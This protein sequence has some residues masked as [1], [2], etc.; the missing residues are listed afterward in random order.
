MGGSAHA[1]LPP[2]N[3][4]LSLLLDLF[5]F[6]PP[7]LL[8]LLSAPMSS[9]LFLPAAGCSA[10]AFS[11][12]SEALPSSR[13][14]ARALKLPDRRLNLAKGFLVSFFAGSCCFCSSF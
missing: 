1:W 2:L 5:F 9:G 10:A 4:P 12:S 13:M 3:D 14:G 7:P 6:L 8:L 11:P